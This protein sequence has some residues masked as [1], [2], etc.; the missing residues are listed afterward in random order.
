MILEHCKKLKEKD[1]EI[2]WFALAYVMVGRLVLFSLLLLAIPLCMGMNDDKVSF[3]FFAIIVFLTNLLFAFWLRDEVAAK[4]STP[5]QFVVDVV[6][7][8][9]FIY[10]TGGIKSPLC[11]L[12][13]IVIISAALVVS[14]NMALKTGLLSCILFSLSVI[15]V[16]HSNMNK[17]S[18]TKADT[19]VVKR[20]TYE[21][22]DN[23]ALPLMLRN[24]LIV[25]FSAACSFGA[26]R[27]KKQKK[28]KNRFKVMAKIILETVH[29][30][31]LAVDKTGGIL[32]SNLSAQKLLGF[33]N[34]T[35]SRFRVDDFF[36]E[37]SPHLENPLKDDKIWKMKKANGDTFFGTLNISCAEFPADAFREDDKRGTTECFVLALLDVTEMLRLEKQAQ[38]GTR[39]KTT[40][41]MAS[42]IGHWIRNPLTSIN[43]ACNLVTTTLSKRKEHGVT[44]SQEDLDMVINMYEIVTK[45][46][47]RLEA[48][49]DEFLKTA[50]ENH[51]KLL[52][53]M[54]NAENWSDRLKLFESGVYE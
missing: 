53:L 39:L 6:V 38:D 4:K 23:I 43:V 42:E 22:F 25:F 7:V 37:K 3:F 41:D 40:L 51:S 16:S 34:S 36:A 33:S 54:S 15:S 11:L 26:D 8:S 52:R 2:S 31:L 28:E 12:Y 50:D 30:P 48:K 24:L 9:G 10:L 13:P 29:V 32:F 14:G 49:I 35:I 5:L 45:E 17:S 44:L 21:A 1:S 19:V 47:D 20:T 46:T 18:S 27:Y